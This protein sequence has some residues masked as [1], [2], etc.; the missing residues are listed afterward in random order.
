MK[1]KSG[2]KV[3]GLS[4]PILIAI[5]VAKEVYEKFGVEFVITSGTDSV[6]GWSSEHYKGDAIDVRTRN[7]R[8]EQQKSLIAAQI[9]DCLTDDYDIVLES[10]HLHIEYDPKQ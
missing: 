6:H 5:M 2:V 7:I 9:K 4:N 8:S 3:L 1:L 10:N